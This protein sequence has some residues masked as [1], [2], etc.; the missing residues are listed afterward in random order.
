LQGSFFYKTN[1]RESMKKLKKIFTLSTP[2]IV[3]IV[4]NSTPLQ[5]PADGLVKTEIHKKASLFGIL[6]DD[7]NIFVKETVTVIDRDSVSNLIEDKYKAAVDRIKK[8][9]ASIQEYAKTNRFNTEY[10]FLVDMSIP[11]G[12]KRL[13]VYNIKKDSLEYSSLVAHGF[14]ST[15]ANN[16]QLE[17]SN[18]PNSYQTSLG[19]Y[20]IGNS[21]YGTF[22]LA[23]KLFGLDNTNS[24]AFERAIVL[25]SQNQVPDSE[26]YP[27]HIAQS[28]GCPMVS[29]SSM[30]VL[31]KYIKSSQKPIL[32]WI[33]N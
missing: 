3:T 24:K 15:T 23:Y 28:A 30:V 27:D 4:A 21:Y 6:N 18:I 17:F 5:H 31:D 10:F 20:K 2:L 33:Y 32:L 12:K 14:G 25:H 26:T 8:Q 16:D 22:G 1:I 7:K 29:P 19:K 9:A 13:F 11:S